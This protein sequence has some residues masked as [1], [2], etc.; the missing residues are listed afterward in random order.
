MAALAMAKAQQMMNSLSPRIQDFINKRIKKGENFELKKELNSEYKERRKEAVKRVIGNM[1]VGKDVSGLFTDVLKCMHTDDLELKKLVYLYLMNYAKSQPEL[2]IL[3]VNSFLKDSEDTNPLIRA[4]A[5]R[6]M[7]CLRAEKVFDYLTEPLRKALKDTDPYV[8]KTAA[9]C[10]AKMYDLKPEQTVDN[11]FLQMLQELLSD[12]NPMVVANS[13]AALRDISEN[14]LA[15]HKQLA[16]IQMTQSVLQK[17]LATLSECTEWGQV[18]ILESLS[19]YKSTEQEAANIIDSVLPRLSHANASVVLSAIRVI[20]VNIE[21]IKEKQALLKKIAPSLISLLSVSN[22]MTHVA[23]RNLHL[24]CSK[25]G[26]FLENEIGMFF[27]KY[28]D[29]TYVKLDK[30]EIL[31]RLYDERNIDQVLT[32]LKEYSKDVDVSF[33]R[34]AIQ[35]IGYIAM[36]SDFVERCKYAICYLCSNQVSHILEECVIVLTNICRKYGFLFEEVNALIEQIDI[37]EDEKARSALFWIIGFHSKHIPNILDVLKSL[38][39]FV[40][41]DS[42]QLSL[43]NTGYQVYSLF[44]ESKPILDELISTGLHAQCPDVRDMSMIYQKIVDENIKI[45]QSYDFDYIPNQF[46]EVLITELGLLSS[47]KHEKFVPIERTKEFDSD[48]DDFE[49][50]TQNLLLSKDQGQGLE[51]NGFFQDQKTLELNFTNHTTEEIRDFALQFNKN[52]MGLSPK[53]FSMDP[54]EP[55]ASVNVKILLETLPSMS[56]ATDPP[57]LVQIALKTSM[58]VVY[59]SCN[60]DE[61]WIK[62]INNDLLDLFS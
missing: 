2:V 52:S 37:I 15:E 49:E 21:Y 36:N 20:M 4:L 8:R 35:S 55:G 9:L 28:D 16:G 29:P 50:K 57:S 45:N 27:C 62:P 24:I 32:E 58:G 7:G 56:S 14:S 51:I 18:F 46:D 13:V 43:I 25:H 48:D 42:L 6:T 41:C 34:K 30:L 22:E 61:S 54:L 60:I 11:G 3:A 12:Q 19:E 47:V 1:T 53:P 40:F 59:F 39:D 17:M 5:V 23:L 38:S 31:I 26:K 44:P 33:S 10:V